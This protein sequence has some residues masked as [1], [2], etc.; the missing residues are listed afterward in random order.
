MGN[1]VF[2]LQYVGELQRISYAMAIR[3]PSSSRPHRRHRLRC[4]LWAESAG[5]RR[6]WGNSVALPQ[7]ELSA[8][9]FHHRRPVRLLLYVLYTVDGK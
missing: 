4:S 2:R 5:V 1:F 8:L 6:S 7:W 9:A 3:S